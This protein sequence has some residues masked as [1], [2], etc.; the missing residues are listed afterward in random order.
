M[1]RGSFPISNGMNLRSFLNII[2]PQSCP[3]CGKRVGR[4]TACGACAASVP[5]KQTLFCGKCGAR[6]PAVAPT[7]PAGRSAKAGLAIRKICH[8]DFPYILGAASDYDNELVKNLIYLLK[9][10]YVKNASAPL[11]AILIQYIKN[12][13]LQFK[14]FIIVPVPLFKKRLRLRGFNQSE[15]IARELANYLNLSVETSALARVKNTKPQSETKNIN[16]RRK[17][18]ENC[19]AAAK[20]ELILKKNIMLI[21]DVATSGTTLLE[22]AKALKTAGARRIIALVVARA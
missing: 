3:G 12:L 6:L 7:L 16:E 9:F 10:K 1:P 22:A 20:P 4:E 19:F 17:N 21:D 2:F 5:I 15:L 13:G 11:G 8:S 18:V 14:N